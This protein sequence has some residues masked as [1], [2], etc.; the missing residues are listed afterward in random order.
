MGGGRL[1]C[2]GG[3]GHVNFHV[4]S[5]GV[6]FKFDSPVEGGHV[7]IG[8]YSHKGT[9]SINIFYLMFQSVAGF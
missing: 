3:G 4:I 6:A 7:N 2:R 5:R 1:K 8:D 9:A